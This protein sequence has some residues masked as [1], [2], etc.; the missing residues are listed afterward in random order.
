[1]AIFWLITL[2]NNQPHP[3]PKIQARNARV[4][5]LRSTVAAL[6]RSSLI[7]PRT[8]G[9]CKGCKPIRLLMQR[10]MFCCHASLTFHAQN[11]FVWHFSRRPEGNLLHCCKT[12]ERNLLYFRKFC[13]YR[14]NSLKKTNIKKPLA[15]RSQ[16]NQLSRHY[17]KRTAVAHVGKYFQVREWNNDRIWYL[18]TL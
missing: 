1:M 12:V 16:T 8:V 17:F 14:T 4:L 2:K 5:R 6:E 18:A 11:S 13:N 3:A 9:G 15:A 10:H 7:G